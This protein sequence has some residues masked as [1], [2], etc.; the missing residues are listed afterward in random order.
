MA[1]RPLVFGVVGWKNSGKT[2]LVSALVA[3]F[4]ARGYRVS[5]V[6]HAH[7]AFDVDQP[8]RDSYC[9]REAG[10]SEVALVSA[11]RVA[12]MQELRGDNEPSLK[13]MLVRLQPCDI[14]V[15]EGFKRTAFP[16]FEVLGTGGVNDK[17]LYPS[18]ASI[19]AIATDDGAQDA[20]QPVFSRSDIDG[21]ATYML[22]CAVPPDRIPNDRT[23]S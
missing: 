9:H 12:I 21:I 15:V 4:A 11:N 18:D 8:G 14:V 16:K 3:E 17:P 20:P 2:T 1:D 23:R 5:T 7:H 10:A 13:E 6:K 22:S 19:C